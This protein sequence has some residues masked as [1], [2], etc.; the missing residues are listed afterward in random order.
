MLLPCCP[1]HADV[2]H[3]DAMLDQY[4][5]TTFVDTQYTTQLLVMFEGSDQ[6]RNVV[7]EGG[8]PV[9]WWVGSAGG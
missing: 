9:T 8:A 3:V 2:P 4:T 6:D 7:A 5:F 1:P